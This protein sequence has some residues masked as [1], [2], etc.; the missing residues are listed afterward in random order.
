MLHHALPLRL[1]K[2]RHHLLSILVIAK[3]FVLLWPYPSSIVAMSAGEADGTQSC[4]DDGGAGGPGA[5]TPLSVLEVSEAL[6]IS[7]K[8]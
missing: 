5:P 1:R 6:G 4:G 7:F 8:L 3:I 2:D